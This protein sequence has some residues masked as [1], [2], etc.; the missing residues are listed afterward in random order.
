MGAYPD[1]EWYDPNRPSWLPYFFDTPTESA[2][3]YGTDSFSGQ[4]VGAAT[5]AG[6]GAANVVGSA[7]G[8][9][10]AGG[11]NAAVGTL[12]LSGFLLLAA[13]GLGIVLLKR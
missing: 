3:K 8:G 9:A 7:A 1:Q 5:A 13:V 11:F 6:A 10:I 4:V 12:D 2:L